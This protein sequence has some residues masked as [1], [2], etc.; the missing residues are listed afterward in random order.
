MQMRTY[1]TRQLVVLRAGRQD[2]KLSPEIT[3]CPERLRAIQT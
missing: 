3:A 1:F 2:I